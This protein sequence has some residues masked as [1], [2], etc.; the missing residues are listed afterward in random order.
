MAF[1]FDFDVVGGQEYVTDPYVA[2]GY[3]Y[4]IGEDDPL[5][6]SVRLPEVGDNRFTVEF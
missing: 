6:A 4:E 2:T 1:D 3:G 5:F